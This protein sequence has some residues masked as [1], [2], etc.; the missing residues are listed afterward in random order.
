MTMY[1]QDDY[2]ESVSMIEDKAEQDAAIGA[3]VRYYFTGEKPQVKGT[4]GA[5][6]AAIKYRLDASSRN[7]R[8]AKVAG[9]ETASE[10]EKSLAAKNGFRPA[11]SKSKSKSKNKETPKG[12]K[13]AF[14]PPT[15]EEVKDYT[16][17]K[18]L[19]IDAERFIDYY[20]AQGWKLSNGNQMK[21][22]RAAARRWARTEKPSTPSPFD[23]GD[24]AW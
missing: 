20:E 11:Q 8:N 4:I 10:I 2:W 21:D 12:V 6:F 23:Y 3:L 5:I 1:F 13:K 14:T 18:G 19:A 17:E 24:D 9:S 16:A 15:I 7:Q 22:W